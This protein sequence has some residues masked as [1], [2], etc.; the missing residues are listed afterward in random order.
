M[1]EK[2]LL[3]EDPHNEEEKCFI[4]YMKVAAILATAHCDRNVNKMKEIFNENLT[5]LCKKYK[6][7]INI[8]N[9]VAYVVREKKDR[10]NAP[11]QKYEQGCK[12]FDVIEYCR[13]NKANYIFYLYSF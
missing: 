8:D 11:F 9:V 12:Y 13:S 5:E 10:L 7:P 4:D 2:E 6:S 3:Q 1:S